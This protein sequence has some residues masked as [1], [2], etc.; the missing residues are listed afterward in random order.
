MDKIKKLI[1]LS[2]AAIM[3][4]SLLAPILLIQPVSAADPAYWYITVNGVLTTDYYSLYPYRALSVDFGLS[5]FG[6]MI[7][8]PVTP[9]VGVGLQYPGYDWAGTYNQRL[10]TARDPFANEYIN[11]KYW[12]N[13]WFIEIRYTHRTYR[14]RYIVAMALFA[15]MNT[16]GGDWLVG[17]PLPLEIAPHGGRKIN[18]YAETEDLK[19][20]YNGPRLFVAECVTHIYDWFDSDGDKVVEHPDET[21][22]VV[23]VVM[24][25]VFEKVKKYVIIFKDIKQ[26]ISGKELDSPINIQFSNREEWDLGPAPDYTSY[27]HFYH[28]EFDTCYGPEW[29]TAPGIMREFKWSGWGI[30]N[31]PTTVRKEDGTVWV[32]P[33]VDGSVRVYVDGVWCEPGRDYTIDLNSGVIT[34]KIPVTDKNWVDVVYK[35]WKGE[36]KY[37]TDTSSIYVP[38]KGVPHKFDVAQIISSDLKYV[39]FKAFWPVV[40]DYT[41]DG[42]ALTFRPLINVSEPDMLPICSEPDIPMVIGEW[43]FM[44]GHGYPAQFRGVEVLGLTDRHDAN[45]DDIDDTHNEPQ[46]NVLDKEVMYLLDEVFNPWDLYDAVHKVTQRHV[47]FATLTDIPA[48][49][50]LK[51]GPDYYPWIP[52]CWDEYC[53]FAERVIDLTTGKLLERDRNYTIYYVGFPYHSDVKI[54]INDPKLKGHVIKVLWSSI[55]CEEKIDLIHVDNYPI[56]TAK[57]SHWPIHPYTVIVLNITETLRVVPTEYYHVNY[58]TGEIT[59]RYCWKC[60]WYKVI[61]DALVGRYE[62]I[63]VGRDAATVDSAGAALISEAFDSIKN[64]KVG[65]AGADMKETAVWNAM[66]WVMHKFGTGNTKEDYKD[67]LGRAALKD[68]WCK[69]WPIASSN[70]IAVG[71]PLANMLAYYFN[72]FTP[73]FFGLEEYASA[74]WANKIIALSCWSQNTYAS[75]ETVGYAVIAT[76]KDINGTIGFLVWGHWGRD[77]YYA[78]QWLWG[79]AERGIPPG[80]IQLQE[81]A[82]KCVTAIILRIDYTKPEHPTFQVVEVLGTISE[83]AIDYPGPPTPDKGGIHE[84]P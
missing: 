78:S 53:S 68:D 39:G 33:I 60:T 77:T 6:E 74:Y 58:E 75:S 11:P 14:D 79:D 52:S 22:P 48:T 45:D 62:W 31:V 10:T 36:I 61:Y 46:E 56:Y 63:V 15:D 81:C 41:V 16:Y 4:L 18:T 70:L 5:K 57:L 29:H 69:K 84:D 80:I 9:G 13:G 49:I 73:A 28:Q 55:R 42:W 43:D 59:F 82:F 2:I 37:P 67:A 34:W 27:V 64:I 8:Y 54:E 83:R 40:S 1:V 72:D 35:L 65:I 24:K 12:I 51:A 76:Y 3:L 7:N 21:W 30:S 47:T 44:L 32:G 26:V 71:G 17:H 66:P 50:M 38:I 19:V 20:L 23:D 25:F